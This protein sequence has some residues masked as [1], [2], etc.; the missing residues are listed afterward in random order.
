[1]SLISVA[2]WCHKK[3]V[4]MYSDAVNLKKLDKTDQNRSHKQILR[5]FK[6]MHHY[7]SIV[8]LGAGVDLDLI[9]N[10]THLQRVSE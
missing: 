4:R 3:W 5:C 10:T 7:I 1:M 9:I 6:F 2:Q 8:F